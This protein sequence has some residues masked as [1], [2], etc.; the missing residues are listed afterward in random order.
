MI[1]LIKTAKNASSKKT[2]KKASVQIRRMLDDSMLSLL[3]T[4][5]YTPM[6]SIAF[7]HVG[8]SNSWGVI[9]PINLGR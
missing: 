7:I 3:W 1:N 2:I 8:K 9:L 5:A 4:A 6:G